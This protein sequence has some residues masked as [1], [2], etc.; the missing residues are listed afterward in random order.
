MIYLIHIYRCLKLLSYFDG[1]HN[2]TFLCKKYNNL[3]SKN[4]EYIENIYNKITNKYSLLFIEIDSDNKI[5]KDDMSTWLGE[6]YTLDAI[7]TNNKLDNC[8]MLIIDHYAIDAKWELL[9]KKNVKKLIIIEDFVKRKHNCDYIINGI[10][11]NP[12]IKTHLRKIESQ[13]FNRLGI[14]YTRK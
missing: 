14:K 9:V 12:E 8:D 1:A 13:G 4:K 3:D 7:K 11:N 2:I 5:V 10:V 6:N